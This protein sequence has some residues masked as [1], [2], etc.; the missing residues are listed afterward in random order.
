MTNRHSLEQEFHD[1]RERD[2]QLLTDEDFL[3]K[4]PN[5]RFYKIASNT[6]TFLSQTF[7]KYVSHDSYVLDYCCGLGYTSAELALLTDNIYGIDI[8]GESVSTAYQNVLQNNNKVQQ[9]NFRE[10]NAEKTTFPDDTFDVIVCNGVLHH[11]DTQIAFKE[12]KRILKDGGVVIANESLG[13]NPIIQAYRY[14]TP[15]IRT[16]WE[17]DHILKGK[18]FRHAKRLFTSISFNYFNIFSILS[19]P[20][21]DTI[22]FKPV[23]F[24][25]RIVDLFATRIPVIQMMSWQVVFTIHK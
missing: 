21:I 25:L 7:R 9:A 8:S 4:Y 15:K 19:I 12:L 10:M 6:S 16:A 2:R 22:L 17:T 5:K 11:L 13:Y 1:T 18:D 20:F 14:L 3:K 23:L 24:F